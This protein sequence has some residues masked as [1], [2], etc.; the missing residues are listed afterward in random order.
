MLN[1]HIIPSTVACANVI[2][3][4]GPE[5][6]VTDVVVEQVEPSSKDGPVEKLVAATKKLREAISD[7]HNAEDEKKAATLARKLRLETMVS[8]REF[9]DLIEALTPATAWT[10]P[11]YHD[12]LFLD[13]NT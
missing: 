11:T 4:H 2:S 7:I 9:V 10:L 13:Q 6:L 3:V 8:I 12:L 5:A 1:Q